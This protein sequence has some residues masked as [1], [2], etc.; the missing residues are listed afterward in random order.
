VVHQV[1]T[2]GARTD[3]GNVHKEEAVSRQL[4]AIS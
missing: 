3:D 4:S 2:G 1:T